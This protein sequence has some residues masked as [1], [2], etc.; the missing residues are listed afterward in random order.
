MNL[1]GSLWEKNCP[2]GNLVNFLVVW[3]V[4]SVI[5]IQVK[6]VGGRL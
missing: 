6:T 4:K 3:F 2:R 1:A 5:E